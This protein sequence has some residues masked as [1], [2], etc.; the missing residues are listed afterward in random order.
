[1]KGM[2]DSQLRGNSDGLRKQP[3][4]RPST[5]QVEGVEQVTLAYSSDSGKR[6]L[7]PN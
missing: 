4:V 3:S 7:D 2:A 6:K 5:E 1:V